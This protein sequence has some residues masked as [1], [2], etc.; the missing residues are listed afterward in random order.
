MLLIINARPQHACG[1]MQ[2][3]VPSVLPNYLSRKEMEFLSI[4]QQTL[5]QWLPVVG[6]EP[7]LGI[8]VVW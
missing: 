7:A 6:M 4:I 3:Y 8:H 5:T 2:D 1:P